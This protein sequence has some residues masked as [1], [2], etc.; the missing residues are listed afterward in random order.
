[1]VLAGCKCSC[2]LGW[3]VCVYGRVGCPSFQGAV[4]P[5]GLLGTACF[6]GCV[7]R[8]R[9]Q[10]PCITVDELYHTWV[11]VACGQ[12][13]WQVLAVCEQII[14]R[15]WQC[16]EQEAGRRRPCEPS[17]SSQQQLLTSQ[18]R[19]A[20]VSISSCSPSLGGWDETSLPCMPWLLSVCLGWLSI[21]STQAAAVLS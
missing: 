19:A 7:G 15:F 3:V 20:A 21:A 13:M 11:W 12:L 10:R 5:F 2:A 18:A 8:G 4:G 14:H 1:M 16:F 17:P 9:L 6:G